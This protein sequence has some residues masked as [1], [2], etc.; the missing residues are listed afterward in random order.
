MH[1]NDR[2]S[3]MT[4]PA[5]LCLFSKRLRCRGLMVLPSDTLWRDGTIEMSYESCDVIH[6]L[7]T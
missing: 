3:S 4:V 2:S 7:Y 5:T 1:V 6:F